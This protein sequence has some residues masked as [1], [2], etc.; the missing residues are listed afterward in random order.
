MIA[1]PVDVG[2][3]GGVRL[4]G[5]QTGIGVEGHPDHV[6]H[7][8]PFGAVDEARPHPLG[9]GLGVDPRGEGEVAEHHQPFDV[10]G[11]GVVVDV[12]DHGRDTGHLRRGLA[13]EHRWQRAVGVEPVQVA[14]VG[15]VVPVHAPD[16]FAPSEDLAD[17]SLGAVDRCR[18]GPVGGF[19]CF[20]DLAG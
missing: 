17:E 1:H 3:T 16:V 2:T 19:G 7:H 11:V 12:G 6:R 15:H 18:S 9:H 4:G 13:G 20:D 5:H 14:V 10:V 8:H